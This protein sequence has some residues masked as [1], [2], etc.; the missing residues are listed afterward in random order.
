MDPKEFYKYHKWCLEHGIKVYP[1]TEYEIEKSKINNLLNA[2]KLTIDEFNTK[3]KELFKRF[4]QNNKPIL[5]IAKEVDGQATF[6]T[7]KFDDNVNTEGV[8]ISKQIGI[9][10]K[11]IFYKESALDDS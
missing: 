10:L 1:I 3:S 7:M 9:L 6:G 4:A 5:F 2:G 8:N 11:A